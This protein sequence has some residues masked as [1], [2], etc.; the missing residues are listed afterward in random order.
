MLDYQKLAADI[1]IVV[2]VDARAVGD[3]SGLCLE[4]RFLHGKATGPTP[5]HCERAP[6]F[7]GKSDMSS[8]IT[9]R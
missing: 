7:K 8:T 4:V 3:A 2:D 5:K 9:H 1:A 6:P